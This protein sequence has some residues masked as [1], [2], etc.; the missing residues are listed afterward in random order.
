MS[1]VKDQGK[2]NIWWVKYFITKY[3]KVC[4]I[5]MTVWITNFIL[6]KYTQS[7]PQNK[8]SEKYFVSLILSSKIYYIELE[9]KLV[10][11]EQ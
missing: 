2:W 10:E 7:K 5:K 9:K 6:K 1:F 3:Y 8:A 11:D 4:Q